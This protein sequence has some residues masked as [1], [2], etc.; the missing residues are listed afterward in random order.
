MILKFR[1]L[2]VFRSIMEFGS[3]T[4]AARMLHVTQPAISKMLSQ[5]ED[6]LGYPFFIRDHGRLTPTSEARALLPEVMRMLAANESVQRFAE[7][8][9][10]SRSG[11][12]TIAAVPSICTSILPSVIRL[13]RKG[14]PDVS[15]VLK[16][17]GNHEVIALVAEHGVDLGFVLAP[18]EDT[19][20][21]SRDIWTSDLYCI[22]PLRHPLAALKRVGP[23]DLVGLPLVSLGRD[24]PLGM[25]IENAFAAAK[26]RHVIAVEVTQSATAFALVRAGAGIAVLDGF[27]LMSDSG[28]GL[29]ARP[30]VPATRVTCRLLWSRHH[31]M[32]RLASKLVDLLDAETRGLAD[33]GRLR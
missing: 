11:R 17:M 1:E 5:A 10:L 2:E 4:A 15:V 24:R 3:I 12:V 9:G 30:F 32:T 18:L 23:R 7:D 21:L 26:Q 19:Q 13:F 29:I 27:S 6:R 14:R 16:S 31:P 25:L 20:T 22:L 28:G 8:L 33:T